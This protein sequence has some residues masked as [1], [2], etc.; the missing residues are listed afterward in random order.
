MQRIAW[1]LW[2]SDSAGYR[3]RRQFEPLRR[4]G[5]RHA[6]EIRQLRHDSVLAAC[7]QRPRRGLVDPRNVAEHRKTDVPFRTIAETKLRIR[8]AEFR[9]P[10]RRRAIDLDVPDG[11]PTVIV[12]VVVEPVRVPLHARCVDGKLVAG[13]TIVVRVDEDVDPVRL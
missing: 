8:D 9:A 10:P 7:D 2:L 11:V 4:T 1:L 13:P 5:R 6:V 3:V 12:I